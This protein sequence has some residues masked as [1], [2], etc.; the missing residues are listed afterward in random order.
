MAD[1]VADKDGI[2]R[3]REY[4]PGRVPET[5]QLHAP[6]ASDGARAVIAAAQR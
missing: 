4:A 5:V 2:G 1:V 3:T 6:Q